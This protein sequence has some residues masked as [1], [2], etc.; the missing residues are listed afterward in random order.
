MSIVVYKNWKMWSDTLITWWYAGKTHYPK[1]DKVGDWFVWLTWDF[2]IWFKSIKHIWEK[3]IKTNFDFDKLKKID[4]KWYECSVLLYNKKQK[5]VLIIMFN[6]SLVIEEMDYEWY[7][8]IWSWCDYALWA[9]SVGATILQALEVAVKY[10]KSCWW[11]FY[12]I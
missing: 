4:H 8:A 1:I 9:L 5:K 10:D 7:C 3:I 6:D 2:P 11:W 12:F